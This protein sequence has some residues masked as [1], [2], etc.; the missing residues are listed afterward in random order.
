MFDDG[1]VRASYFPTAHLA[2]LGRPSYGILIECE[3]KR[4]YF[5]GDLSQ[6]LSAGDFP[7]IPTMLPTDLF[8]LELAH[9]GIPEIESSLCNVLT[10]RL[11][12]NHVSPLA[13][14][15]EIETLKGKYKYE[16]ITPSDMDTLGI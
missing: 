11:A 7:V 3:G 16:I 15:E 9:F 13:K 5:S 2:P 8:V 14:Y 4:L 10:R 6:N 1:R 12:F